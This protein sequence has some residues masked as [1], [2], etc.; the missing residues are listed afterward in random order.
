MEAG[1]P[2]QTALGAAVHRA[3]HTLVDEPVLLPDPVLIAILDGLGHDRPDTAEIRKGA[4][5]SATMRAQ[6]VARKLFA[7]ETLARAV[8]RGVDQYVL[9]G[10]GLD[11][12]AYR[13]LY[14]QIRIFEVDHPATGAWKRDC[15]EKAGVAIPDNVVYAPIDFERETLPDALARAGFDLGKPAVF[16]WLG[17]T[18]Y[19]T[20]E[21]IMATLKAVGALS[22]GTELCFDYGVPRELM[23][24]AVQAIMKQRMDALAARGEPWISFFMPAEMVAM[25][26]EAGFSEIEDLSGVEINQRWFANRTDGLRTSPIV[27]IVRTR[28]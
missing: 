12:F 20:R 17:V 19:L 21:A 9:L 24:E 11:T 23:P 27:H 5:A 25:L 13:A 3:V 8:S 7:E 16:A 2:S 10:A 15:L 6:I 26:R 22:A 1:K 18:V 14:P 28:V 4:A